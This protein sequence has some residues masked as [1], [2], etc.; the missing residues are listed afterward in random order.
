MVLNPHHQLL[1][2]LL[3]RLIPGPDQMETGNGFLA[4]GGDAVVHL[5]S[6][7]D[8]NYNVHIL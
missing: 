6:F 5:A 4:E 2:P 3:D 1:K 8:N 7:S